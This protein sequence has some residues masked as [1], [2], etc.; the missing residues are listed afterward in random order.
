MRST[1]YEQP[2][3]P[4][5]AAP[6]D[7]L[8]TLRSAFHFR[9]RSDRLQLT[10]LAA[11]LARAD[12]DTA[13]IHED[14]RLFAHRLRGAAAIFEATDIGTAAHALEQA[15]SCVLTAPVDDSCV[16]TA[17]RRLADRLA[18]TSDKQA[19]LPSAATDRCD[20]DTHA[21]SS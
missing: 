21:N 4:A 6:D 15:A 3:A 12:G 14:I 9:L 17:L 20:G 19:S 1:E 2:I 5:A 16:W 7:P 11:A 13:C 18:A 10:T 8:E